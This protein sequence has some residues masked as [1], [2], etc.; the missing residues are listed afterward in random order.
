MHI[1]Y[2][3]C[4]HTCCTWTYTVTH[5]HA[6]LHIY[7]QTFYAQGMDRQTH[8]CTHPCTHTHTVTHTCMYIVYTCRHAPPCP[9]PTHILQAIYIYL[10]TFFS[11]LNRQILLSRWER[12]ARW[13]CDHFPS[14]QEPG[15]LFWPGAYHLS[16]LPDPDPKVSLHLSKIPG[17]YWG[18]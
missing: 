11:N 14:Q 3:V 13:P 5:M 1:N 6:K 18:V 16:A 12:Q 7:V 8:T 15:G 9:P 4:M 10:P 2:Y 17:S